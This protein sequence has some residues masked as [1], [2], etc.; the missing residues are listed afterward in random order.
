[1]VISPV[2]MDVNTSRADMLPEMLR[3]ILDPAAD[4]AE[5]TPAGGLD[6]AAA[7]RAAERP[8]GQGGRRAARARRARPHRPARAARASTGAR[9]RAFAHPAENQGYVRLNLRGRERDGIVDPDE[10]DALMDEIADG[11]RTFT[12]LDGAPA[13]RSVERVADRFG[14]GDRAHLLPDL[15][16]RWTD[17]PPTEPRGRALRAVRHGAAPRRRQ[18]PL[19]QPHRG[20]RVGAGRARRRPGRPRRPARRGSR[21][22]PPPRRR[23]PAATRRRPSASPCSPLNPFCVLGMTFPPAVPVHRT[24]SA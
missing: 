12:D 7:G 21:T 20:R 16:V 17:R 22:S 13:V 24:T 6:L 18:R 11:L 5:P 4:A 9:T 1:M 8:A 19:G 15:I 14:S 23:S 10:A 3:A 2:G